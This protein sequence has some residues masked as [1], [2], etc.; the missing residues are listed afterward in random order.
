[1]ETGL[2]GDYH[3]ELEALS[4]YMGV[5]Y[6]ILPIGNGHLKLF[7]E[8]LIFKWRAEEERASLNTRIAKITRESA[9]YSVLFSQLKNLIDLTDENL[10][11]KEIANLLDI[12]LCRSKSVFRSFTRK[13]PM[14]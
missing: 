1:M 2:P 13:K 6:D 7:I 12:S 8:S 11:E 9:D 3:S 5:P 14:M 4:K 10:I